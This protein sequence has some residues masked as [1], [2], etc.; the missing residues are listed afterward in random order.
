MT[1]SHGERL[2]AAI[3]HRHRTASMRT[4]KIT[5]GLGAGRIATYHVVA[6]SAPDAL[7]IAD[8]LAEADRRTEP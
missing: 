7:R 1:T 6:M 4:W 3:T 5:R 2:H 8:R